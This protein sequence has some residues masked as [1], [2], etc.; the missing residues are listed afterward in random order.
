MTA[1]SKL[2]KNNLFTLMQRAAGVQIAK[3]EICPRAG[4][5]MPINVFKQMCM[6]KLNEDFTDSIKMIYILQNMV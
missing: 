2:S 5:A 4:S 3:H 1:I 6:I